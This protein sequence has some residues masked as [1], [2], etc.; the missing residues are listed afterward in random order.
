[1]NTYEQGYQ[2]GQYARYDFSGTY[3][4]GGIVDSF[5]ALVAREQPA[6]AQLDLAG[7]ETFLAGFRQ[8]WAAGPVNGQICPVCQGPDN[9]HYMTCK[10][11]HPCEN[12]ACHQTVGAYYRFC[13]SACKQDTTG[14]D[15]SVYSWGQ[16]A[17]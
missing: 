9:R 15:G 3:T 17:A 4:E 5:V 1:M 6:W 8:G 13:S 12:P 2:T 14:Q 7:Q 16:R 10:L 11:I